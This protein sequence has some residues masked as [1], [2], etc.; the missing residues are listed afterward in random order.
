MLQS[1]RL[2]KQEPAP[3]LFERPIIGPL[4]S[5]AA[6]LLMFLFPVYIAYHIAEWG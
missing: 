6:I 5:V 2:P 1:L 3:L 4:A